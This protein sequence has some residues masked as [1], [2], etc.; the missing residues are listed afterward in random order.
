MKTLVLANQKGGTGKSAVSCQY[1]YFLSNMSGKKVI[2]LDLDHQ[3]NSSKSIARSGLATLS[4]TTSAD[5]LMGK[6]VDEEADLVLVQASAELRRLEKQAENHNQYASN[7]NTFLSSVSDKFDF[8]IIDTNPNPDIRMTA[9][10]VL[11][12]FVLSPVQLNQESIDGI[13]DLQ[14]DIV[15]IKS[16]LN[17][18]LHFIGI[19]PNLVEGTP[20][21]KANLKQITEHYMKLMISLDNK[22]KVAAIPTRTAIAEAQAAG[23]PV[24]TIKKTSARETWARLKPIFE[25][26][27]AVMEA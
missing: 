9:A 16:A 1:A 23:V 11:A 14:K 24:W 2:F 20:F 12:D 27:L 21:Q 19:L 10:L 8:C 4:E 13:S 7:L 18:K 15:K 3:G 25:K 6:V 17:P 22:G 5:V 26:V